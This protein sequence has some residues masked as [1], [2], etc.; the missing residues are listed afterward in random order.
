[1]HGVPGHADMTLRTGHGIPADPPPPREERRASPAV[2]RLGTLFYL[3]GI[4]GLVAAAILLLYGTR[5]RY[6]PPPEVATIPGLE[7]EVEVRWD[8][9]G[10]FHVLG[11]TWEDVLAAQG[12][13][14]A[15]DRLFQMEVARLVAAG[16]LA[17]LVGP[18][19]LSIDVAMRTLGLDTVAGRAVEALPDSTRRRLGAYASG[20]NAWLASGEYRPPPELLLLGWTPDRWSLVDSERILRLTAFTLSGSWAQEVVRATLEAR[21]GTEQV[22]LL[23]PDLEE[24]VPSPAEAEIP[25][26]L[27]REGADAAYWADVAGV[28][29]RLRTPTGA[30]SSASG[31]NAW[32][33]DGSRSASG[34]P[35]LAS[36]PHLR[37]QIPSP[38][39]ANGLHL[40]D[41]DLVGVSLPGVPGIVIGRTAAFAWGMTNGMADDQDLYVERPVEGKEGAYW[42][43][44]EMRSF[45]VRRET[46]QVRGGTPEVVTVRASR[47]GPIVSDVVGTLLHLEGSAGDSAETRTGR[48]LPTGGEVTAAAWATAGPPLALRWSGLESE[49]DLQ[50]IDMLFSAR[51]LPQAVRALER[52]ASAPRNVVIADTT[53]TIAYRF[54][55]RIPVR[56]GWDG[57]HPVPGW[58]GEYEWDRFLRP[59]ELPRAENPSDGI[60]ISAN[61]RP[62]ATA[63]FLGRW[64]MPPN[65]AERIRQLLLARPIHT[66]ESFAAIQRDVRSP[67]ARMLVQDL[68][69][70]PPAGPEDERARTVLGAWDGTIAAT[71]P[72]ALYEA[73]LAH[74]FREL[75]LDELGEAGLRDYL[76]FLEELTGRY[77][78]IHRLLATAGARWWDDLRTPERED[79]AAI[80]ERAWGRAFRTVEERFGPDPGTWRWGAMH[81]VRFEHPFGRS[82]P[83]SGLLSRGPFE[84]AGDSDT[85][86][87]GHF[88]LSR[89]Y[90]PQTV[91]TW[92]QVVDLAAPVRGLEVLPPGNSAHFLSPHYADQISD[93]LEGALRPAPTTWEQVGRAAVRG[94]RLIPGRAER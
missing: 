80:I 3:L 57:S 69:A 53:G 29:M 12:W 19:G 50:A 58:T 74:F 90:A 79:R 2:R 48:D 70:L 78:V 6:E 4:T 65:R 94:M 75:L 63:S 93:W 22:A 10:T 25:A 11:R 41:H 15:R 39:V 66:A 87:N 17:E 86:L 27:R 62:P 84:L 34:R 54:T 83:L 68:L 73:F 35:L 43:E 55:G 60:L 46:L 36:D 45:R 26:L 37:V 9:S 47:H 82:G 52:L 28:L 59:E 71:G 33:V 88:T 91:P 24:K 16:R 31:S 23:L 1:M 77:P 42:F 8:A 32:V 51:R 72:S 30:A 40:P 49:S 14:H 56:R 76:T 5:I 38:L 44:G 21:F 89:P 92:R 13:L 67:G 81:A 85:V 18:E 7:A 20:V 61:D 64:W